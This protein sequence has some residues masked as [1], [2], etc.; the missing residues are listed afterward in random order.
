MAQ[1]NSPRTIVRYRDENG[2]EPFT[3][4]FN[5]LRDIRTQVRIARRIDRMEAGNFGDFK[6]LK[7]GV[8]EGVSRQW[9]ESLEPTVKLWWSSLWQTLML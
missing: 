8:F 9:P 2:L 6:S 3:D 4:W 7:E 5:E 1:E